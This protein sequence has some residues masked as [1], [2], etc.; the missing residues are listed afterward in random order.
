MKSYAFNIYEKRFVPIQEF[1]WYDGTEMVS[2]FVY[3]TYGGQER[4]I[5]IIHCPVEWTMGEVSSAHN[6]SWNNH[7]N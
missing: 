6:P 5:D 4:V 1:T 7:D 3:A 2:W